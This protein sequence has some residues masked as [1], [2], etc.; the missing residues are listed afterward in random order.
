VGGGRGREANNEPGLQ[1]S[2]AGL[3]ASLAQGYAASSA[4]REAAARAMA[5]RRA[6]T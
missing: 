5:S 4:A 6:R 3:P 1:D 2:R